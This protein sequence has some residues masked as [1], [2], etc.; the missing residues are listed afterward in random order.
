VSVEPPLSR[1][2]GI[3]AR[4][5][6]RDTPEAVAA[7]VAAAGFAM[8]HWNFA[9]IGRPTLAEGVER[10]TFGRVRAAFERRGI[11]IP[12]ISVTYN[13]VHPDRDQRRRQTASAVELIARVRSLGADVAT[14]CSGTREPADMWRG[15]PENGE[16]ESWSDLRDTLDV[17]LDAAARAGI[18]LGIEPEPG[19]VVR[20]AVAAA[21]LLDELGPDAPIGIIFD[22]ANLLTAATLADQTA[23]LTR[24]IDLLG[25]RVIG[26]HAKD[27]VESRR[28]PAGQGQLDY[29]L[30]FRLLARLPPI[31][32]IAQDVD[33]DDAARVHDDLLRL[34]NEAIGDQDLERSAPTRTG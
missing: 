9:A 20:D 31:P 17:L 13:L 1:R 2:L 6:R 18:R 27:I 19:N 11:V 7:A 8:A 34:A 22:P 15:H 5:F 25:H 26:A 4:T 23:I 33:E 12:S 29:H 21:R 28:A 24:A 32:L 10:S 16:P 14:L 30:V 3:F